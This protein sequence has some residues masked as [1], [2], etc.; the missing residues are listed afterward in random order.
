MIKMAA[1][2]IPAMLLY[3]W[4]IPIVYFLYY[5]VGEEAAIRFFESIP[6]VPDIMES[7]FGIE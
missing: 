2:T 6:T 5:F 3:G 7:L 4:T 1:L